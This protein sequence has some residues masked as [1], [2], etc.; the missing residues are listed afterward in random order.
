MQ[1]RTFVM[2]LQNVHTMTDRKKT[3]FILQM[4]LTLHVRLYP[5]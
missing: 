2:L 1:L 3:D 4:Q 5:C